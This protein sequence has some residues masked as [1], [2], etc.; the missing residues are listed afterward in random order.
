MTSVYV[1]DWENCLDRR[2]R[3]GWDE[4]FLQRVRQVFIVHVAPELISESLGLDGSATSAND[5]TEF[6]RLRRA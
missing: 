6:A 4:G 1:D 3:K 5:P 2:R